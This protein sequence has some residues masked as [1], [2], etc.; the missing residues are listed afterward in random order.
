VQAASQPTYD[1]VLFNRPEFPRE[2]VIFKL[3]ENHTLTL[4]FLIWKLLSLSKGQFSEGNH[5]ISI[6]IALLRHFMCFKGF[7]LGDFSSHYLLLRLQSLFKQRKVT[8]LIRK[9]QLHG[10]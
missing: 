7:Q 8:H 6:F 3:K 10:F 9:A 4:I 2:V 5:F 1:R